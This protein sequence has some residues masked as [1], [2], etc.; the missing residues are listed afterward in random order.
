MSS[1]NTDLKKPLLENM[2]AEKNAVLEKESTII[3]VVSNTFDVPLSDFFLSRSL[4]TKV[5]GGRVFLEKKST[6]QPYVV[7]YVVAPL[8]ET[9]SKHVILKLKLTCVK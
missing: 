8:L 2:K 4:K 5:N 9:K 7:E 1:V 6:L 3:L